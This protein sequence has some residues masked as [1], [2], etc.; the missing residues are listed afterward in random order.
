LPPLSSSF[1]SRYCCWRFRAFG[2]AFDTVFGT[3]F[4]TAFDTVFGTG[5]G[6]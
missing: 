6:T 1:L 5:F 2:T 3:G 4:G